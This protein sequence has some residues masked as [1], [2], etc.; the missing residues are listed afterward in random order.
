MIVDRPMP[1]MEFTFRLVKLPWSATAATASSDT[2]VQPCRDSTCTH[3]HASCRC[4]FQHFQQAVHR[5]DR[6]V[7]AEDASDH[8]CGYSHG[9]RLALHWGSVVVTVGLRQLWLL[10][11]TP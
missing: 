9:V 4:S 5:R 1:G 8:C 10:L 7:S 2:F 6:R 11:H 3:A